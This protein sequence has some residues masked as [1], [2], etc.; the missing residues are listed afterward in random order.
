MDAR[1][2]LGTDAFDLESRDTPAGS[3]VAYWS[4]GT[5]V[6]AGDEADNQFS[7]T[8]GRDGRVYVAGANGTTVNGQSVASLGSPPGSGDATGR[9]AREV[10]A[11]GL[12][13]D[14]G[15]GSDQVYV[16]GFRATGDIYVRG[17][18]GDDGVYLA[19][20]R[21]GGSTGVD[22]G[23]G[24]DGLRVSSVFAGGWVGFDAGAGSD[25]FIN[26]GYSGSAGTYAGGFEVM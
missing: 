20:T 16:T 11:A 5:L 10:T 23:S 7:V 18:D 13:V 22:L 9:D 8:F 12:V 4:G 14:A 17:G 15:G 2:R 3:V 1:A 25:T 21:S 26:E 24:N 19:N 6:V